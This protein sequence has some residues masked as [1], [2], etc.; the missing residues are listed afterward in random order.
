M[1]VETE[2]LEAAS[3]TPVDVANAVGS[4][5][6]V[7]LIEGDKLGSTGYYP[8]AMLRRD[9]PKVFVKGTP[10]YLD[11]QTPEMK[12]LQ[13]NG[14]VTTYAGELAE[15]AVYE[16]DGLYAD[17]EVFEHQRPLIKSLKDKI[18]I[19]IRGR[20]ESIKE[21]IGGQLVPVFQNLL[22]AHSADFVVKAGAG[23]KIVQI[24][25]SAL[26]AE[27]ASEEETEE[28]DMSKEILDAIESLKTENNLRF[29]ALEEAAKPVETAVEEDSYA[30]ALEIAEAFAGSD[31]DAEGRKRV[32]ALH[33]ADSTST[34]ASLI[35]AEEAYVKRTV[36][37]AD[38]D[39]IEELEES[40]GADKTPS[41]AITPKVPT[42]WNK[43]GNK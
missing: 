33:K 6:R 5:Y 14:S 30:K 29:T 34:I 4:R 40:A 27:T 18:G 11:H 19:S 32:L 36:K 22:M 24:L 17:I 12:R 38:A 21:S 41:A 28:Q 1:P 15:D 43:K 8:A 2:I 16:N 13:P 9:G 42:R 25:E 20:G 39:G 26:E 37:V 35:E 7:R 31:L 10:M 23:G 3:F